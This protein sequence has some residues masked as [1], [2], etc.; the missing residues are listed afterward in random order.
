MA[1][2]PPEPA[3]AIPSKRYL[4]SIRSLDADTGASPPVSVLADTPEEAIERFFDASARLCDTFDVGAW[5]TIPFDRER[6]EVV[7]CEEVTTTAPARRRRTRRP[8]RRRMAASLAFAGLFFTGAALSAT[9]GDV[10]VGLIDSTGEIPVSTT[11]GAEDAIPPEEAPAEEVPPGEAPA[12]E[13]PAEEIPPAEVAPE[14]G[15]PTPAPETSPPPVEPDAPVTPPLPIESPTGASSEAGARGSGAGASAPPAGARS[16]GRSGKSG[17]SA[18]APVLGPRPGAARTPLDP[19][20]SA[21]GSVAT[22]WLH[23]TLPDP[24]PPAKRLAPSFARALREAA[25]VEGIGWPLLLGVLR[26]QGHGGRAPATSAELDALAARLAAADARRHPWRAALALEGS[27]S[28]AD[29][30]VALARYNAAVGLWALTHG[31]T[32]A[33]P[34]LERSVLRDPRIDIYAAG[35]LD[36]AAGRIDVRVLVLI[37]YLRVAHGQITVSSLQTGHGLWAR[38]GFISAHVYGL[39]VDISMVGGRPIL[40][41]QQPLG[42]T[43]R[44]VRNVLLLPAEIRPQQVISLL[45]LG[46]PS[47]PAADHHDHIHVGF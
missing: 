28:F 21:S 29:Q 35:R 38:P 42:V 31:L 7:F 3:L 9:A 37:R 26:A 45:G 11:T 39:A 16:D 19:E 27:V 23:R 12:E 44:A 14:S 6:W 5:T 18:G 1:T 24:T 41:N 34:R 32:A 10:A 46:G 30:A 13:A 2:R 33:K 25:R 22:V 47:F 15:D 40:G 20:T 8:R 36:V 4:I 43:E 17:R